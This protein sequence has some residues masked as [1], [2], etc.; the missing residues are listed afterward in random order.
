M[1]KKLYDNC[2]CCTS[3]GLACRGMACEFSRPQ[4]VYTCD[5]CG[6]EL[7]SEELYDVDGEMLCADCL[8]GQYQT[9]A[10]TE[11]D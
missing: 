3:N 2:M 9:V 1:A 11:E 8:L 7:D 10:Q 4:A 5:G 6:K